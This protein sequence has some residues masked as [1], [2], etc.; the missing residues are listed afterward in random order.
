MTDPL[1]QHINQYQKDAD[2]D[3]FKRSLIEAITEGFQWQAFNTTVTLTYDA[4][5]YT[6]I[7][8]I[9]AFPDHYSLHIHTAHSDITIDK[10]LIEP[11]THNSIEQSID[12]YTN[13]VAESVLYRVINEI[14]K[15]HNQKQEE[16]RRI[17]MLARLTANH[18][19]Q[20]K[21]DTTQ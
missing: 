1:E 11:I 6:Y 12:H 8:N 10:K 16:K 4:L 3:A 7:G 9:S 18:P 20:E 21:E 17:D 13:E 2:K 15:Q 19:T 5:G 14:K